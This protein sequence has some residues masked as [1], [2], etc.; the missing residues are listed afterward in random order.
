MTAVRREM[1]ARFCEAYLDMK[2]SV[3]Q[4][5]NK[6]VFKS[7]FQA[8]ENYTTAVTD[9][10]S[11]GVYKSEYWSTPTIPMNSWS[12]WPAV[13][14][15]YTIVSICHSGTPPLIVASARESKRGKP[16][17]GMDASIESTSVAALA[18]SALRYTWKW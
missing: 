18:P 10:A 16:V 9:I 12:E 1:A 13:G 15:S 5:C 17:A 3:Y 14:T 4:A 11:L 2:P 6:T 7:A 8:N